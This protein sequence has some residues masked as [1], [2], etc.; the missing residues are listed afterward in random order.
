MVATYE[1]NQHSY[2]RC[3]GARKGASGSSAQLP[4]GL[5]LITKTGHLARLSRTLPASSAPTMRCST[6]HPLSGRPGLNPVNSSCWSRRARSRWRRPRRAFAVD[7]AVFGYDGTDLR[8]WGAQYHLA[9]GS[10]HRHRRGS[11]GRWP[12]SLR[13]LPPAGAVADGLRRTS[14]EPRSCTRAG[15]TYRRRT[16]RQRRHW[17]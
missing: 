14:P 5:A 1:R 4:C 10:R 13:Q 11:G 12:R 17:A 9:C 6:N 7:G 15:R 8:P 16:S 2:S 3:P